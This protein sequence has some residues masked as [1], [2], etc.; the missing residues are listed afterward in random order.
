MAASERYKG[1]DVVLRAMASVVARIPNVTYVVVGGGDDRAR[2]EALTDELGLRGHVVFTGEVSDSDVAALYQR[3]EVFV[4]PARTVLDDR[5]PKGEG[6][7]IVFLEAMAFGKPVVGPNCGAPAELIRHGENGLLVIPEDPASVAEALVH[8]LTNPVTAREM[9]KAGSDWVRRHY[10]YG[11][12]RERLRDILPSPTKGGRENSSR[13]WDSVFDWTPAFWQ[14]WREAPNPYRRFKSECDRSLT[15]EA[16]QLGDGERVLEVGCGYGF[17]SRALLGSAKIRWVGLDR[18]ESMVRKLRASLPELQP[19]AFIGDAHHLPFPADSF[20]K[21]LC[22]GVLMHVNDEF[23]A[24]KEMARVLRP[25]GVLLCSMNNALSPFSLPVRL[26]NSLK[27]GFIQNFRLPRT[28]CRHFRHLG[29]RLLQLQGDSIFATI[30]LQVGP[31]SF[32]PSR[33]FS[34]LRALDQWAVRRFAWLA[35]EVWFKSVKLP[36]PQEVESDIASSQVLK[37]G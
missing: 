28:Y 31:Y 4:L 27:K 2:L 13:R 11:S 30:S 16:L 17:I 32:P 23:P 33:A 25:G 34:T 3:S 8:L 22:T 12:F 14:G 9:G 10:S 1:H 6:F 35:Y 20:D 29:L 5:N 21:V 26:K 15:L 36:R 24:L 37:A 18:S 7:G 19:D